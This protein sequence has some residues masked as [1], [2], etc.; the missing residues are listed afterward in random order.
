MSAKTMNDYKAILEGC[1]ADLLKLLD[2]LPQQNIKGGESLQPRLTPCEIWEIIQYVLVD[3]GTVTTETKEKYIAD[4]NYEDIDG[5]LGFLID[6]IE[7]LLESGLVVNCDLKEELKRFQRLLICLAE[8]IEQVNCNDNAE[9]LVGRLFCILLQL[10]LVILA[11]IAKF[12]VLLFICNNTECNMDKVASSFCKCLFCDLSDELDELAKLIEELREIAIEFIKRSAERC[13]FEKKHHE[14]DCHKEHHKCNCH[15]DHNKHDKCNRCNCKPWN[16]RRY[17][18]EDAW[19]NYAETYK[20]RSSRYGEYNDR[21]D[22]CKYPRRNN[23]M[24]RY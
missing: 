6:L 16:G 19:D 11:I 20:S 14:C 18:R 4:I 9:I 17:E 10:I 23:N 1:S 5:I 7:D 15:R 3:L 12:I 8:T 13:K 2:I 24:Y 22:Y 21:Y